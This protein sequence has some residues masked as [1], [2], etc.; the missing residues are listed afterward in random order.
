[1]CNDQ[2]CHHPSDLLRCPHHGRYST[3]HI[4]WVNA[5]DYTGWWCSNMPNGEGHRITAGQYAKTAHNVET[6]GF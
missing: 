6:D 4:H 1:M 2:W 3:H 5:G